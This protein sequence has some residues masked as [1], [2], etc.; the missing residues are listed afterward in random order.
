MIGLEICEE[1]WRLDTL[2]RNYILECDMIMNS[3]SS[4]FG[5]NRI[6]RRIDCIKSR[7]SG[8]PGA[9]MY[10][11]TLG[12]DGGRLYFDGNNICV[13]NGEIQNMGKSCPL[14]D[15]VVDE[16][17]VDISEIRH[18]RL[19][20]VNFLREASLMKQEVPIVDID[21]VISD[22]V[23]LPVTPP[24]AGLLPPPSE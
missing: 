7:M 6:F 21:F 3:N 18:K 23:Y 2:T 15:I 12:C 16:V 13:V 20:D 24:I 22:N 17:V 5:I 19:D 14:E 8:S 10:T 9:Y 1:V 11:N 4:H